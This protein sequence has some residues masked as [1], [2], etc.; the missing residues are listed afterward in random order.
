MFCDNKVL[1]NSLR[2]YVLMPKLSWCWYVFGDW[3]SK[4]PRQKILLC[5]QC[6]Q[7]FKNCEKK[8]FFGARFYKIEYKSRL[9]NSFKDDFLV[10]S[11]PSF[12][13]WLTVAT[14][15]QHLLLVLV[16]HPEL[17]VC[18]AVHQRLQVGRIQQGRPTARDHLGGVIQL[19]IIHISRCLW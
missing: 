6:S 10:L 7:P 9:H 16:L 14:L 5:N 8:T 15:M 17:L 11:F 13:H 4:N 3:S 19:Y 12:W 2:S 1:S 18:A